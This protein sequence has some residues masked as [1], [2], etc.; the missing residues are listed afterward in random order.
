[1]TEKELEKLAIKEISQKSDSWIFWFPP[2]QE[3]LRRD[4]FGVFDFL[5]LNT[6]TGKVKFYQLTTLQHTSERRRKI[7]NWIKENKIIPYF[8]CH[9]WSYDKKSGKFRT[10]NW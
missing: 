6:H 10:E 2:K 5:A 3:F 8:Y 1:M 7:K 9:L 4:I